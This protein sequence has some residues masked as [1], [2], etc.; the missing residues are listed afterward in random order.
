MTRR[1]FGGAL[2]AAVLWRLQPA[3][4]APGPPRVYA[5]VTCG[6]NQWNLDS[7]PVDS[8]ATVQAIFEFLSDNFGLK[9]IYW[10]GEQDRMLLRNCRFRPESPVYYEHFVKWLGHLDNELKLNDIA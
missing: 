9:R 7:L 8:P 3:S 1:E 6:D 4:A 2:G 5:Y 10:R